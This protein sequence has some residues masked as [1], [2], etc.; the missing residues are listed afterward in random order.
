MKIYIASSWKNKLMAMQLTTL[1]RDDGHEVDCFC[2]ENGKRFAFNGNEVCDVANTDA[3]HFMKLP[4]AQKVFEE[5][6]KWIDWSEAVIM[7]LPCG[8]S[9]HLEAGYARGSGKLL[10]IYGKM[11]KGKVDAMYGFAH[12][13]VRDFEIDILRGILIGAGRNR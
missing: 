1:L 8:N 12:A 11:E 5:D 2:E 6:K 3:F 4:E 10:Y 9:A 7:L 13:M